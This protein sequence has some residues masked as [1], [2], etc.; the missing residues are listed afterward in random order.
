MPFAVTWTHDLTILVWCSNQLSYEANDHS[1]GWSIMCSYFSVKEMNV[2]DVYEINHVTSAETKSAVLISYNLSHSSLSMNI[3]THNWPAS[4]NKWLHSFSELVRALFFAPVS[5]GHRFKS[6][7]S[8]EFFS[9]FL[10]QLHKMCSQPAR[11]ILYWIYVIH[12]Y[13]LNICIQK[14]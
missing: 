12:C 11:I 5:R 2:I 13:Q 7:W 6:R 14:F 10:M 8:P 4:N 3:Q 1:G 9:G